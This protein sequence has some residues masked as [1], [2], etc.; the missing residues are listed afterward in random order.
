MRHDDF[1]H[2][3]FERRSQWRAWLRTNHARAPGVWV[4]T[5]KKAAKKPSPSYEELVLEALCFGWI[6]S[7]TRRVDD[8]RSKLY[9]CPRKKGSV[10]AATNKARVKQLTAE[11]LM[12]TS[13][14]AAIDRAKADGSW[15][16]LA[17]SDSLHVP[18]E[19][20]RAFTLH[21][22]SKANFDAFP[23][24]VRKQLIF[25][26]DDAKKD[27]TRARRSEEIARQAQQNVR[28]NQWTRTS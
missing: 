5:Y 22:G 27:E 21:P 15:D 3:Q 25:W 18:P 23:P 2:V 12:T 11:G 14:Q 16:K 4:I 17:T 9:F 10:W 1:E 20:A 26:V 28:A 6:D 8:E 19:L 13:G 24:G 7:T